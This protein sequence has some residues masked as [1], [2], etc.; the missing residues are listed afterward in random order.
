MRS[1]TAASGREARTKAKK[2][3]TSGINPRKNHSTGFFPLSFGNR[4]K[5]RAQ[6]KTKEEPWKEAS[7]SSAAPE[8]EFALAR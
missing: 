2:N 4:G 8:E 6:D 5:N 7:Q 1:S 3:P